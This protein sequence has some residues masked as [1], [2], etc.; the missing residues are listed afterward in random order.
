MFYIA[1]IEYGKYNGRANGRFINLTRQKTKVRSLSSDSNL[2]CFYFSPPLFPS[3]SFNFFYYF[4]L[5][6]YFFFIIFFSRKLQR[7]NPY[8]AFSFQYQ[9]YC[10][11]CGIIFKCNQAFIK[12]YLQ[13][14]LY[15][16][17]S[18]T[19]I[20]CLNLSLIEVYYGL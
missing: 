7:Q 15:V 5:F 9:S 11:I 6:F 2:F 10:Q 20:T 8:N 1:F 13:D 18:E 4:F 3:F 16:L 14:C 12:I 17:R 19:Y